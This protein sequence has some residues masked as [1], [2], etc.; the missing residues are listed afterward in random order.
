[1]ELDGQRGVVTLPRT[2]NTQ[3]LSVWLRFSHGSLQP[4]FGVTQFLVDTPSSLAQG[5]ASLSTGGPGSLW[6]SI[7]VN[8]AEQYPGGS[9]YSRLPSETWMHLHLQVYVSLP[10]PTLP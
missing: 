1:M 6:A 5:V 2:V 3:A 7:T 4:N 10:A 9:F 8:G